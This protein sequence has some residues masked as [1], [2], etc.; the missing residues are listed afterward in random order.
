VELNSATVDAV[1]TIFNDFAGGIYRHPR[2]KIF[3]DEGRSF[4][5][6]TP[7]NFDIIQ[8][9]GV[10]TWTA[11]SQGALVL[12]ENFLYTVEAFEDYIHRLKNEGILS[13]IRNHFVDS[14][15]E[16][17]RLCS[18]AIEALKNQGIER[19]EQHLVVVGERQHSLKGPQFAAVLIKKNPFMTNE[20]LE[21]DAFCRQSG[22]RVLYAPHRK[23]NNIFTRLILSPNKSDIYR[24]YFFNIKPTTDNDPFFFTYFKWKSLL[25]VI[26]AFFPKI[27]LGVRTGAGFYT[28]QLILIILLL[29]TIILSFFLIILPLFKFKKLKRQIQGKWLCF[30]YFALVGLA[31]MFLNDLPIGFYRIFSGVFALSSFAIKW[32]FPHYFVP[33]SVRQ[34]SCEYAYPSHLSLPL[35]S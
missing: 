16:T 26:L 17:L 20:I 3:A 23:I 28:G 21:V 35:V 18:L 1:K 14:P 7:L 11:S 12:S 29:Q 15:R 24:E 4:I 2:V 9:T 30:G 22:F 10:D 25:P 19:P 31:F 27:G 13:I 6:R 5:R 8:M 32:D 34:S 33:L